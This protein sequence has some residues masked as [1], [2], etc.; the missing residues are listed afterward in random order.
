MSIIKQYFFTA[1]IGNK[2]KTSWKNKYNY[3]S[4]VQKIINFFWVNYPF[5]VTGSQSGNKG[6]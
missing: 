5:K 1:N 6:S 3:I 2:K 4:Q